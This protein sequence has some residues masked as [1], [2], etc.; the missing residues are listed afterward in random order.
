MIANIV[1]QMTRAREQALERPRR[2]PGSGDPSPDLLRQLAILASAT[3]KIGRPAGEA[4]EPESARGLSM[5]ETL[6]VLRN[7]PHPIYERPPA[8]I[9]EFERFLQKIEAEPQGEPD[10]MIRDASSEHDKYLYN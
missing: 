10:D 1:C 6:W 4:A 5:E 7:I 9:E 8:V 3:A 2:L